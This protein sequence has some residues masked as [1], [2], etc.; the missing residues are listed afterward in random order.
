MV[1][2]PARFALLLSAL[3]TS[4]ASPVGALD[5][6]QSFELAKESDPIYRAAIF[7]KLAT[8]DSLRL[9]WSKLLP[10]AAADASYTRVRQDIKSS[11]NDLFAVGATSFP[12]K[13]YGVRMSQPLFRMTE[14][15]GVS[16]ARAEVKQAAAELDVSFQD[17]IFRTSD[18]Y[19]EA[20]VAKDELEI[21]ARER[22]ALARQRDF[23]Q[24]RLDSGLGTAPDVYE[25]EARFALADADVNAAEFF[26]QDALQALAEI[27]GQLDEDLRPLAEEFPLAE[28]EP[29]NA[30]VWVR[31][32]VANNPTVEAQRQAVEI[33]E[34]E[35]V[36]QRSGHA[37]IVD[38]QASIDNEDREGSQLGGGSNVETAEYGVRVSVP[39]FAGGGVLFSTGRAIDLKK[40]EQQRLVQARRAVERDV[41][42]AFQGVG[43]S[44]RRLRALRKTVEV[45]DLAVR[46]REKA[47]RSGVDTVIN[48]LNAERE[49]YAALRDYARGRSEY[50]RSVLRL[51][52][53]SGALGVE[54]LQQVSEWLK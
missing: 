19:L 38:F 17:L 45:Q 48:V 46:S 49:L 21:R 18:A 47:V 44:A 54:D 25:A 27:T 42:D 12:A 20:L 8:D 23:A 2:G 37:P 10:T 41:R 30:D 26:L 4:L 31:S 33:A 1:R 22:D 39:L 28:P 53:S 6:L 51:E 7:D 16:Q 5:L 24:K 36:R 9:A 14:W 13:T 29:P 15:V 11:D 32:A 35:V 43:S 3:Y 50:V 52:Q 40:R 34:R